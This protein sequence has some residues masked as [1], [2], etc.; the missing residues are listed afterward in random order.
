[1][2]TDADSIIKRVKSY[3]DACHKVVPEKLLKADEAVFLNHISQ[4]LDILN[5]HPEGHLLL[6]KWYQQC[7]YRDPHLFVS[8]LWKRMIMDSVKIK[9]IADQHMRD[10]VWGFIFGFVLCAAPPALFVV[11]L[12]ILLNPVVLMTVFLLT[13]A[14]LPILAHYLLVT[15]AKE[16]LDASRTLHHTLKNH[17]LF[18]EPRLEA[19]KSEISAK[20]DMLAGAVI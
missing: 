10:C 19:F 8:G 14:A 12:P 6:L 20:C 7:S 3:V 9:T 18:K 1:M 4:S 2:S 5:R 17:G 15:P 13:C 16:N 11:F